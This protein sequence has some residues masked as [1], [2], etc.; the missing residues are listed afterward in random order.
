M[1]LDYWGTY[2]NL[3]SDIKI[4]TKNVYK[5]KKNKYKSI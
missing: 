1:Q 2:I 4:Y 3:K 5:R